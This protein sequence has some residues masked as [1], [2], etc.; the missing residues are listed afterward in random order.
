MKLFLASEAKHPT[1]IKKLN[2]FVGGLSDKKI[3]YIPTAANGYEYGSWKKGDSIKTV[4]DTNA[5]INIIELEEQHYRNIA[6]ELSASDIIWV[7]GGMSGYLL[8]WM[9]RAKLDLVLPEILIKGVI[10]VGSSAGSMAC[11]STQH[12][13]EIYIG[14]DE[15][16]ASVIPGLGLIDFE[17]YPHFEDNLFDEINKHWQH[18]SLCLI[19]NGEAVIVDGEKTTIFGQERWINKSIRNDIKSIDY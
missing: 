19:K 17:I 10:Y 18:G 14:E 2:E 4:R 16:G 1:S 7:A 6:E 5:N 13:N 8:Y 9:R 15:P 12:T 11:S 3:A